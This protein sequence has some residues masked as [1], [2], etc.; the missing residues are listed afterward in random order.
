MWSVC[1]DLKVIKITNELFVGG[2]P[3]PRHPNT[4]TEIAFRIRMALLAAPCGGIFGLVQRGDYIRVRRLRAA[5]ASYMMRAE[6]IALWGGMDKAHK[7]AGAV[8]WLAFVQIA[9]VLGVG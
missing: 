3:E 4:G 7:F 8:A 5:G 2:V 6:D 1:G 9:R